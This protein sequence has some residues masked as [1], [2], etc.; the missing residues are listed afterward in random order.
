MSKEDLEKQ[1]FNELVR[2]MGI[3][4][5]WLETEPGK[6]RVMVPII[7]KKGKA[8]WEIPGG[9][10]TLKDDRKEID[11]D[12]EATQ[13][14]FEETGLIIP[15]N[16]EKIEIPLA[17]H[18]ILG[19]F[20]VGDRQKNRVINSIPMLYRYAVKELPGITL[21]AFGHIEAD[22]Y[23][24][25]DMTALYG[26]EFRNVYR[27][28]NYAAR[29]TTTSL[30]VDPANPKVTLLAGSIESYRVEHF[31]LSDITRKALGLYAFWI[32]DNVPSQA[33]FRGLRVE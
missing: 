6:A 30:F 25:I 27:Q 2:P 3:V 8:W 20:T 13:E 12:M 4:E 16:A 5:V 23:R 18:F 14:V 19:D 21:N 11:P 29:Q 17:P 9:R 32:M 15:E 24:W 33:E 10:T 22:D 26:S 28:V 7:H 1:T 31:R